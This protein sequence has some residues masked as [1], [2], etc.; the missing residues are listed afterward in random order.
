MIARLPRLCQTRRCHF[1]PAFPKF[2]LFR[3]QRAEA[4]RTQGL[5]LGR[6]K[7][8]E[9]SLDGVSRNGGPGGGLTMSASKG[10]ALI[11]RTPLGASLVPFC[12]SRKEH[13]SVSKNKKP[14]RQ[15]LAAG[16]EEKQVKADRTGGSPRSRSPGSQSGS[17]RRW[18]ARW[19]PPWR[20]AGPCTPCLPPRPPGRSCGRN[21]SG[22]RCRG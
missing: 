11:G 21:R 13:S 14:G 22:C 3:P 18:S 15:N 5:V 16:E 4:R 19:S 6:R 8:A 10:A 1:N 20:P 17:A 9:I 12:A 7:V 2:L